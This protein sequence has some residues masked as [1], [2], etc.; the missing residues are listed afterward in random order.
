MDYYELL[1]QY[2]SGDHYVNYDS[3]VSNVDV[4]LTFYIFTGNLG[5]YE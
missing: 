2:N 5:T 3:A 1:C 4:E